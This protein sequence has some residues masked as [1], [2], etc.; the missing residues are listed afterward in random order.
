MAGHGAVLAA[1]LFISFINYAL[2]KH[3]FDNLEFC[4]PNATLLKLHMNALKDT[5]FVKG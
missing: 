2:C 4:M 1:L 5:S 3:Y